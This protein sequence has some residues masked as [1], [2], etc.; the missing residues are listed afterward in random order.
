MASGR[1]TVVSKTVNSGQCRAGFYTRPKN[2]GFDLAV[3][4]RMKLRCFDSD[5]DSYF[6][7][8]N[9]AAVHVHS[10]A[11]HVPVHGRNFFLV[12]EYEYVYERLGG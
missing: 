7:P 11:V 1:W 8:D 12:Y 10:E 3:F 9:L 4:T 6:D 5:F 2:N